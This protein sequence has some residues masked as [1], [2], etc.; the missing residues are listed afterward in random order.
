MY[1]KNG[2]KGPDKKYIRI[3]SK[4][5][6]TIPQKYYDELGFEDRAECILNDGVLTIRP[7]RE[8]VGFDFSEQILADLI[9][10]GYSGDELLKKFKVKSSEIKDAMHGLMDTADNI[11]E[12]K[13]EYH[14][15]KDMFPEK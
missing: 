5:Q 10:E 9:A 2:K 15:V 6:I 1:T 3:S 13:G 4:R 11:A 8:N 12:G 7:V 14:T